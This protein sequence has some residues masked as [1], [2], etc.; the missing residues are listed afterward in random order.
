MRRIRPSLSLTTVVLAALALFVAGIALDRLA[1]L[2]LKQVLLHSRYR[3]MRVYDEGAAARYL[4]I[5]NSRAGV[6]FPHSAGGSGEFFNLGNGGMGVAFATAVAADYVDHHGAPKVA[7]IEMSFMSDS[8]TG[9]DAAGLARVFSERAR[10]I[11]RQLTWFQET[12]EQVFHLTRFNHPTLLNAVVGLVWEREQRAVNTRVN[13][14]T[15]QHI[16]Q[17]APYEMIIYPD[18]VRE[19]TQLISGLRERGVMVICVLSPI[20]PESREKMTNFASFVTSIRTLA[21]SN[22]AIFL[23]YSALIFDRKLFADIAHL[24]ASGVRLFDQEL[25]QR[26]AALG[27]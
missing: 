19:M 12:A 7:I 9:E 18:N 27:D 22:G 10:A 26:I 5:G 3:Y 16:E 20:L 23:D 6:H 2:G 21:E 13:D 24:N 15:L 11:R 17:S 1:E 4:I 8:R 14:A 25:F